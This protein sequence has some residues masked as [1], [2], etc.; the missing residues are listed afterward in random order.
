M[1]LLWNRARFFSLIVGICWKTL[2]VARSS[3]DAS[4]VA[5]NCD[6]SPRSQDMSLAVTSPS[7]RDESRL[8]DVVH[9][10]DHELH[11]LLS[12]NCLRS[13]QLASLYI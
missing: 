6:P 2:V 11:L 7:V 9:D 12:H 10:V 3:S 1:H 4:R 13:V 5:I 8:L